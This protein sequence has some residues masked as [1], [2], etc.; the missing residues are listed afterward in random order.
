MRKFFL[1]VLF[2]FSVVYASGQ[3]SNLSVQFDRILFSELADTL[4]QLVPVKI[5]YSDKWVDTLYLPFRSDN[6]PFDEALEKSLR[7]EGFSF[8]I[9]EG[10]MVVLSKGY[11]IKTSFRKDY[12]EYLQKNYAAADTSQYI[13][14]PAQQEEIQVSDES[15]VFKI[16]KPSAGSSGSRVT[17]TGSVFNTLEGQGIA[18]AVVYIEKLK[19]GAMTNESGYYSII[20]PPGQYQL[21]YRMVGMKTTRRNVIIYSGGIL[22]VG[23]TE[24]AN[25]LKE[26][27]ISA[28]RENSVRNVRIGIEK[29]NVK[30]LRQIPMG[31]GE[32]DIIKSSLMLPGVQTVGEA[33]G[34]YNVRGGSADQNLVLLNNAPIIN[35]SHFFGFFS[36]F[37]SDL[38]TDVT[39]YKSGMPAK[40]GGRLSS[41]MEISLLEGNSEKIRVS[42]GIS[43]FTGRIL[44]EGPLKKEKSSF[45]LGTRATYSDWILEMLK[46]NKL[47]KSRAGFYDIQAAVTTE[48]NDK[49]SLSLSGYLSN[50]VFSYY[51]ESAFDYGNLAATLNWKHTFGPKLSAR[52]YAILSN[53]DYQ[54]DYNQD[55]TTYSSNYYS[56]NQKIIRTDFTYYPANKHKMEFGLDAVHY[57][58]SPG[59]RE[60]YGE[61]SVITPRSLEKE[62]A[63]E[64]A[65]YISDEFE[66]SSGLLISGGLRGVM[67]TSFGPAT[68]YRYFENTAMSAETIKDT[69]NYNKG[70]IAGTY[71][72]LEFR[73]SSRLILS[74]GASLK[75]GVQRVYQYIT[76]G[77]KHH[78]DVAHRC[79]EAERQV[80]K[81]SE[82]RSG[83]NW[84]LQH[85]RKES[86]GNIR[87][88]LLQET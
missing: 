70:Q 79:L 25:Q 76:Y 27:V 75:L 2:L 49:N 44:F 54:L 83:F 30:M 9:T 20:V 61:Y 32:A 78:F 77:I 4:E 84:S 57:T 59:E 21:E 66:V 56:L 73:L 12:L 88:N 39:L 34:G 86:F 85:L 46:D 19:A 87:G 14:P 5:Y 82:G 36:A 67:F 10:N 29:I 50:D 13:R 7:R 33:S 35:S 24:S 41:V 53:Y 18:G 1:A 28:N 26:I 72:G 55:S 60:P 68:D 16:G 58:L 64:P 38:I 37:N 6:E 43:P 42:G 62:R 65:L 52:F 8:I 17:L 40:Y 47:K 81:T 11:S 45:I 51:G 80:Y 69:I 3:K 15:R 22:D 31:M 71:P 48:I 74:P 23:M 63:L